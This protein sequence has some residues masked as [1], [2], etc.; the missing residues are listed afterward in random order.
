MTSTK[1]TISLRELMER[2]NTSEEDALEGQTEWGNWVYDPSNYTL[3]LRGF[4]ELD[5]E[6]MSHSA[7][8]L[9]AIMQIAGKCNEDFYSLEDKANLVIAL[10]KLLKP[11]RYACS[12]GK[13]T[14]FNP[15]KVLTR[16]KRKT[17]P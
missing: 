11:Q 13:S 5:L 6:R 9:D 12:F 15:K 2:P 14:R 16:H 4:Y 10:N 1:R 7:H 8:I 3:T 17:A